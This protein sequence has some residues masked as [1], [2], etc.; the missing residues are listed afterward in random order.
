MQEAK[1]LPRR[2]GQSQV[3]HPGVQA[4]VRIAGSV[5]FFI[6]TSTAFLRPAAAG[7]PSAVDVGWEPH[8]DPG[9]KEH[10][11]GQ[12]LIRAFLDPT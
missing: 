2:E 8:P 9:R 11:Q 1:G 12:P 4:W 3:D 6:P 10:R 7:T 5:P